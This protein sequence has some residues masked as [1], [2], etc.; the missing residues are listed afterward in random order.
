MLENCEEKLGVDQMLARSD[1]V[2]RTI[3]LRN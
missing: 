2:N 1:K 3:D